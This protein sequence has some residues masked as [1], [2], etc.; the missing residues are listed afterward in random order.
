MASPCAALPEGLV[1][2]WEDRRS[3]PWDRRWGLCGAAGAAERRGGA[4]GAVHCRGGGVLGPQAGRMCKQG[5]GQESLHAARP[6]ARPAEM[7]AGSNRTCRGCSVN[8]EWL[9]MSVGS[10]VSL[11]AGSPGSPQPV[12]VDGRTRRQRGVLRVDIGRPGLDP[13]WAAGLWEQVP[14]LCSHEGGPRAGQGS[15]P[16]PRRCGGV[17]G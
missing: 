5:G 6:A 4:V 7:P 16:T 8:A 11:Q 14:G 12:L 1:F 13:W 15:R 3:R 2:S 17:G 10:V 9:Q